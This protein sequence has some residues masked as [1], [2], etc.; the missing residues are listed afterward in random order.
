MNPECMPEVASV[1]LIGHVIELCALHF[2]DSRHTSC[3]HDDTDYPPRA[4][5]FLH[6]LVH[7]CELVGMVKEM[8]PEASRQVIKASRVKGMVNK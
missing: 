4:A 5:S 6:D 7:G 2:G 1:N 8:F 3:C